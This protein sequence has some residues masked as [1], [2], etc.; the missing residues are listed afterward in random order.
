MDG[1]PAHAADSCLPDTGKKLFMCDV[2][3]N[4]LVR[5]VSMAWDRGV[6]VEVIAADG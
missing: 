6:A 3:L 4:G 1:Y 5:M 2:P